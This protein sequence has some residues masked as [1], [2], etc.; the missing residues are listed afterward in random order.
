MILAIAE[1]FGQAPQDVEN[2]EHYWYE[3]AKTQLIGEGID[4]ERRMKKLEK[5]RRK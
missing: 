2:W 1:K 4:A 3:R 5:S